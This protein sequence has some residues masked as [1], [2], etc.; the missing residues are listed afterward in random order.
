[1]L[2]C[3]F[4]CGIEVYNIM[5]WKEVCLHRELI[6]VEEVERPAGMAIRHKRGHGV[7]M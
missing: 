4:K 6:H 2:C 3:K 7:Q 5:Y 1:M